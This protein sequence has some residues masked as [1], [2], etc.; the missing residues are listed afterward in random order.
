MS[1]SCQCPQPP[2][3]S[4]RCN[5]DQ[6]A[7]CGYQDGEIVSGCFDRP[8][9][10]RTIQDPEERK[11]VLTNWVL[12]AITGQQRSDYEEIDGNSLSMLRSGR[13]ENKETGTTLRFSLPDDLDLEAAR[14]A[15]AEA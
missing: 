13:Y 3:G 14:M 9:H 5:D 12:A 8:D 2:G 1:N 6:L 15:V 11:L 10:S 4:I 7:M